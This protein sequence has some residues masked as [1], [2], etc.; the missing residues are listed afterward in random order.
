MIILPPGFPPTRVC[1]L[2]FAVRSAILQPRN[3]HSSLGT[4]V[5]DTDGS[6][7]LATLAAA[8][9]LLAPAS[10]LAHHS[11]A[12]FDIAQ[13]VELAGTLQRVQ[14]VNPHSLFW[15][16]VRDA[17]GQPLVWTIEGAGASHVQRQLHDSS[18]DYLAPGQ[19]VTVTLRPAR[20]GSRLGFLV[21]MQFADG[22]VL[23]GISIP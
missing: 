11:I 12:A 20:D 17:A 8:L 14:I 3:Q 1:V 5:R 9:A 15:V 22:R 16:S 2:T 13:T 10:G 6:G 21:A 7:F 4:T 23:N 19:S 18:R